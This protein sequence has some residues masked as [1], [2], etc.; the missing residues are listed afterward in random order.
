M[1]IE[2]NKRS[3]KNK[4]IYY[5]GRIKAPITLDFDSGVAFFIFTA[6]DGMEEMQISCLDPDVTLSKSFFKDDNLKIKLERRPDELENFFYLAKVKRKLTI[7]CHQGVSF[8][9]FT[10]KEGQEELQISINSY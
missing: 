4:N 3:D 10:S 8:L 1:K 6:E 9:I 5:F 2:I 7:P